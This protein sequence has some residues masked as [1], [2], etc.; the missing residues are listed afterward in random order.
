MRK[1]FKIFLFY[2][3]FQTF[4]IANLFSQIDLDIKEPGRNGLN[5][6]D[7]WNFTLINTSNE[8]QRVYIYSNL[9]E[10]KSGKVFECISKLF[11]VKPGRFIIESNISVKTTVIFFRDEFKN[12]YYSNKDFPEGNYSYNIYIKNKDE[13]TIASKT[14]THTVQNEEDISKLLVLTAPSNNDTLG[15]E[16]INFSWIYKSDEFKDKDII[17]EIKA[18]KYFKGQKLDD[19]IKNNPPIYGATVKTNSVSI[20]ASLLWQNFTELNETHPILWQVTAQYMQNQI[21]QSSIYKFYLQKTKELLQYRVYCNCDSGYVLGPNLVINGDFSEGNRGFNSGLTYTE[22]KPVFPSGLYYIG[23]DAHDAHP[24]WLGVSRNT[25]IRGNILMCN[26]STIEQNNWSWQQKIKVEKFRDYIFCAWLINL[27]SD[28]TGVG[29]SNPPIIEFRINGVP[30][31]EKREFPYAPYLWNNL[32]AKWNSG[33]DSVAILEIW[34]LSTMEIGNDFGINEIEFRKC[35]SEKDFQNCNCVSWSP[36]TVYYLGNLY[37][38]GNSNIVN[39]ESFET[40]G[41]I[42]IITD[43]YCTPSNNCYPVYKWSAGPSSDIIGKSEG[44]EMPLEFIPRFANTEYTITIEGYCNNI[45]CKPFTIKVKT[46][47]KE[48]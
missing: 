7:L 33:E 6:G 34:D 36:A 32:S 21:E 23:K 46:G 35:I 20:P 8:I 3:F 2:F 30:V 5:A 37:K 28:E 11:E 1:K 31:S 38:Q 19:A 25:A 17:Y 12:L 10:G 14:M 39:V 26:G 40:Y 18:V 43:L 13:N 4:F 22:N 24:N 45:P 42:K 9:N 41:R 27:Y 47:I 16:V 44:S 15:E 48:D 29:V